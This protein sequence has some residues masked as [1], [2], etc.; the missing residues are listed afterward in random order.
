MN[1][2]MVRAISRGFEGSFSQAFL[3][4]IKWGVLGSISSIG[5]ASYYFFQ[6]N[7]ILGISFLIAGIFI[8]VFDS[9]NIYLS[10]LNGRKNFKLTTKFNIIAQ[11]FSFM[12]IVSA[13][14]LSNNIIWII[15]AYFLSNS[16]IRSILLMAT[17]KK[18]PINQ[19]KDGETISYGKSLSIMNALGTIS[20]QIDKIL[21]FH[22]LGSAE[23]AVYAFAYAPI[24]QIRSLLTNIKP[25]ALP[26]FAEQKNKITSSSY[27]KKIKL[28]IIFL[29]LVIV[30]YIII[31]PHAFRLLF[32]QYLESIKFSQILTLSLFGVIGILNNSFLQ[33]Q[34]A[35]KELY[36]ITII[37]PIFQIIITLIGR[38]YLGLVGAVLA[39]I[40]FK[41]SNA[42]L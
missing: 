16:L 28:L 25:L 15:L 29:T 39:F 21:I 38:I 9:F 36:I 4:K 27:F 41:L 40:V 3:K 11:T 8:P 42:L 32:P 17:I 6:G 23:L 12:S 2:A 26:K 10:I 5:I 30:F 31:A 34:L 37:I 19:N 14:V 20:G 7:E 1:I 18:S 13:L 22:Y 24:S 33:A 35:K